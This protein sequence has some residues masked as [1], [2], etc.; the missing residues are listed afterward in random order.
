MLKRCFDIIVSFL[1]LILLSPLLL[2]IILIIK[3][4]MP[5]PVIFSQQRTGRNGKSF[6]IYKFR[7]MILDHGGSS[8]SVRGDNRITPTGAKLR[9][10]KLDELPELWNVLKGDMSFVGPRP[11]VPEYTERL[12][13]EE[14][15]ILELRPGIT[16][17]AT[18]KY[19][20][21]EEILSSVEDPQKFNDEVLW[22]DKVRINLEYYHKKN[23]FGDIII[24]LKTV[25]GGSWNE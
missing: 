9:K 1:G 10:Y 17:P 4:K 15:K 7:S 18:L 5:G 22:P 14:K 24:I 6:T 2:V 11:D 25:F 12:I 3:L 13:G 19:S 23:F 16:G 21:E 8:I 20:N